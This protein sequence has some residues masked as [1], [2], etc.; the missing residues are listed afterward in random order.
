MAY[1]SLTNFAANAVAKQKQPVLPSDPPTHLPQ[2]SEF[3]NLK[4]TVREE[5][6][7]QLETDIRADPG[8]A[9]ASL[10]YPL[11]VNEA[12]FAA[13]RLREEKASATSAPYMTLHEPT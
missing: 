1:Q 9:A 6:S 4:I 12:R 13:D 5:V 10:G 11:Q 7:S 3:E 8:T 2:A